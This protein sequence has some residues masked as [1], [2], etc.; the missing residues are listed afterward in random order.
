MT[1]LAPM[2]AP[3]TTTVI[4]VEA[5]A[6]ELLAACD[7]VPETID[8]PDDAKGATE[9]V[10]LL[11]TCRKAL[12]DKR[13]TL[14]RPLDEVKTMI[15]GQAKLLTEPLK[16]WEDRVLDRLTKYQIEEKRKADAAE[17]AAKREAEETALAEAQKLEQEGRKDEA[18]DALELAADIP[19]P[20]AP[21]P[22]RIRS[23]L[24]AGSTLQL[25]LEADF[26]KVEMKK[27]PLE[28]LMV[29]QRKVKAAIAE[30]MRTR[31][32]GDDIF[33]IPGIPIH[34]VAKSRV[35]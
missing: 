32:P 17:A 24:G 33:S 1:D 29:D 10:K 34:E 16:I 18:H 23:E 11:R 9:M 27:V 12:D 20:A 5:R 15:M 25:K 22:E 7:R 13:M 2:E 3:V 14:T 6:E 30:A 21:G 35:S 19:A 28:W 4:V 8:N 31:K 26:D